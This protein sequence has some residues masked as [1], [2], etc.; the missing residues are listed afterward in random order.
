MTQKKTYKQ[1]IEEATIAG[2]GK[3]A[4]AGGAIGGTIGVAVGSAVGGVIGGTIGAGIDVSKYA[5]SKIKK[6]KANKK[7]KSNAA[8][9]DHTTP[10][11]NKDKS[12]VDYD[13]KRYKRRKRE[14][15]FE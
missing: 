15:E 11:D 14:G 3:G 7:K 13:H 4:Y 9:N 8:G 1:F 10:D 12:R 5:Y 6:R 2:V